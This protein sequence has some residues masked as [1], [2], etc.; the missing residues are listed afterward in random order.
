MFLAVVEGHLRICC[1]VY[2]CPV[3]YENVLCFKKTSKYIYS[4]VTTLIF[5]L[6]VSLWKLWAN[7]YRGWKYMLQ[8]DTTGTVLFLNC[9]AI[10]QSSCKNLRAVTIFIIYRFYSSWKI[11]LNVWLI[12]QACLN[13]FSLQNA[14]KHLPSRLQVFRFKGNGR[15]SCVLIH[16]RH[17]LSSLIYCNISNCKAKHKVHYG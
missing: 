12:I 15:V 1:N 4:I 17:N 8:G 2:L 5:L 9:I 7:A 16:F 6:Q 11:H 3:Q 13:V 14:L 10:M